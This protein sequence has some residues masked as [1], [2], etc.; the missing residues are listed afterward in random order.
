M[1]HGVCGV[2]A[3]KATDALNFTGLRDNALRAYKQD[4]AA[5]RVTQHG[6]G[7]SNK[8]DSLTTTLVH[9]LIVY[10]ARDMTL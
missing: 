4:V 10:N 8:N 1:Q 5:P 7:G 6:A 3:H 2:P 9:A